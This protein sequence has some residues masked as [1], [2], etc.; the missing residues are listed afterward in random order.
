MKVAFGL[1]R[2]WVFGA[3]LVF[4]GV[5]AIFWLQP[6]PPE[7]VPDFSAYKEVAEKKQAFFDFV[8]PRVRIENG[9][10]RA[11]RQMLELIKARAKDGDMDSADDAQDIRRLA[12]K[13]RVPNRETLSDRAVL[14]DLL[15][16]VDE[17][18]EGLALAQA[19]NESAWGTSRFAQDHRNFFGLWCFTKGCGVKPRR[20]SAESTHQV[21]AFASVQ[22]GVAYY[23]LTLNSHPAYALLRQRRTDL[24]TANKPITGEAVAD[25]LL[26]YSERGQDYVDEIQQMIRG[27]GLDQ[28]ADGIES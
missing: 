12:K 11:E 27:N 17:V 20:A 8:R 18:P 28:G 9:N 26:R 6:T 1:K 10:I 5:I 7:A 2:Q 23:L 19:A 22:A 15:M 4:F 16:R 14:N 13:Y 25:G 21:A 24:R 3:L